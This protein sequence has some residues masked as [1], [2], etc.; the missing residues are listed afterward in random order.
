[1]QGG[2][3]NHKKVSVYSRLAMVV[4]ACNNP[5]QDTTPEI[6]SANHGTHARGETTGATSTP[7][8]NHMKAMHDAMKGMMEQMHKMKPTGDSDYD[9]AMMMRHHHLGS[10]DRE[11]LN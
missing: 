1:M 3:R 11:D 7:A 10:V 9:F 6:D 5:S 8:T 2:K 4:M